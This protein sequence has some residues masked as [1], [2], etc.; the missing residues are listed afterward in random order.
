MANITDVARHGAS[1]V[2]GQRYAGLHALRLAAWAALA[3]VV[4]VV[5]SCEPLNVCPASVVI[6]G[7]CNPSEQ[8]LGRS[9]TQVQV[10]S[11]LFAPRYGHTA[12]VFKDRLYVIG[13]IGNS[14]GAKVDYNDVWSSVDGKTW[15]EETSSAGFSPRNEH[16]SV[17]FNG[18]LWVIGGVDS[19]VNSNNKNDVWNSEDGKTWTQVLAHDGTIFPTAA[20][21]TQFS[22]R[23]GH[24][25]YA[26]KNKLWVIGGNSINSTGGFDIVNDVWSSSDGVV[27]VQETSAAP[28]PIRSRF[29]SAVF[30]N[31]MWIIG[32]LASNAYF[33]DAWATEDG[34]TWTEVLAKN[35]YPGPDELPPMD[36]PVAVVFTSGLWLTNMSVGEVWA[37]TNG[38]DWFR[39]PVSKRFPGYR[40]S[41][42]TAFRQRLWAIGGEASDDSPIN[43]IYTI[44]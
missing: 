12:L 18:K 33:N 20:S 31:K 8:A 19:N 29:A 32:G 23:S 27:W 11:Q 25:L 15:R 44:P 13:G 21:A 9:A 22:A 17:V 6:M 39:A 30:D 26:Y 43:A 7:E 38:A 2:R 24:G 40:R 10:S 1:R 28:Y 5:F 36:T 16:G 41:S 34:K 4:A 42:I 3:A 35:D 37:S 14:G